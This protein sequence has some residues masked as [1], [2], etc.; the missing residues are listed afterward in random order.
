VNC[1]LCT[2]RRA[3]PRAIM[4]DFKRKHPVPSCAASGSVRA[5]CRLH[6]V[7]PR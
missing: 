5:L 7:R 3:V 1:L 2:F 6:A 4:I